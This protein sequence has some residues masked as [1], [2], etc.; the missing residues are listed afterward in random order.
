MEEVI[1][2]ISMHMV[3]MMYLQVPLHRVKNRHH[4]SDLTLALALLHQK[5]NRERGKDSSSVSSLVSSEHLL[6]VS[7]LHDLNHLWVVVVVGLDLWTTRINSK[8]RICSDLVVMFLV[9]MAK[10][11]HQAVVEVVPATPQNMLSR[12]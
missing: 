1:I 5:E 7:L 8:L 4:R 12:I 2:W 3:K 9:P 10:D 6:L 11:R